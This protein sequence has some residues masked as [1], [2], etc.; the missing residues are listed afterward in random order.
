MLNKNDI[1]NQWLLISLAGN[2]T[3]KEWKPKNST[4]D[5]T[6][7]RDSDSKVICLDWRRTKEDISGHWLFILLET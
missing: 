4:I 7:I 3:V 2:V 6:D 5:L 1:S